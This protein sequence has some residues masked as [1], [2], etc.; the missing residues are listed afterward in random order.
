MLFWLYFLEIF[1][2]L[3]GRKLSAKAIA[4]QV[5]YPWLCL[6]HLTR[7]AIVS[8][9]RFVDVLKLNHIYV[10][11]FREITQKNGNRK[12]YKLRFHFNQQK[13]TKWPFTVTIHNECL[14]HTNSTKCETKLYSIN[15]MNVILFLSRFSVY[16]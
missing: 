8:I 1:I 2:I 6:K 15:W 11:N 16:M 3:Q 4:K 14:S 9:C 10:F 12:K 5:S 7:L 13:K